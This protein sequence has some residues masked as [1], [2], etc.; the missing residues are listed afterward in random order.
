MEEKMFE[1]N[2]T[3]DSL[4]GQPQPVQ[5][6]PLPGDGP[7]K[8]TRGRCAARAGA[9]SLNGAPTTEL[10]RHDGPRKTETGRARKSGR[11]PKAPATAPAGLPPENPA[12]E[13]PGKPA[14]KAAPKHTGKRAGKSPRKATP[15]HTSKRAGKSLREAAP[16]DSGKAADTA[17]PDS[18]PDKKSVPWS[19]EDPLGFALHLIRETLGG[20]P[21]KLYETGKTPIRFKTT[22]SSLSGWARVTRVKYGRGKES[23]FIEFG[24]WRTGEHH[25]WHSREPSTS[26]EKEAFDREVRQIRE[27]QQRE[28]QAR[29]LVAKGKAARLWRR[30][31]AATTGNPY[32]Q[33][34]NVQPHSARTGWGG[35]SDVLFVPLR[36]AEWQIWNLQFIQPDGGK[37]FLKGGRVSGLFHPF[38]TRE[39]FERGKAILV[40]EGWA[41][42]ATLHEATG[43]PVAAAM[44]CGNLLPAA[45]ALREKFPRQKL[46]FCA[47]DDWKTPGNPGVTKAEKAA[48]SV[49]AAVVVPVWS[50]ARG[51]RGEKDT[52]FN[53]LARAEGLDAVRRQVDVESILS[54]PVRPGLDE[55]PCYWLLEEPA[56]IGEQEYKAGVYHCGIEHE[57]QFGK[58]VPVPT[59]TWL[60]S[61]I[62]LEA[63]TTEWP[64][65]AQGVRLAVQDGSGWLDV[66]L[67][68]ETLASRRHREILLAYGASLE[69]QSTDAKAWLVEYLQQPLSRREYTTKRTGW[70]GKQYVLPDTTIGKGK[71]ILFIGARATDEPLTA[72]ELADWQKSVAALAVGNPLLT[73]SISLAF[74]GPLLELTEHNAVLVHLVGRSTTGKTT[75]LKVANSVVGPPELVATWRATDNGLEQKALTYCDGFMALDEIGQ[76]K[77]DVLDN[78]IYTLANGVAKERAKAYEHGIGAAPSQRWRVAALSTGEKTLETLLAMDK[79]N[80]NAGQAVRFIEIPAEERHGAFTELHGYE[81]GAAL[82]DALRK[83][84]RQYYG[85]PIRAFLEQLSGEGRDALK[86]VLD[87][88]TARLLEALKN[89]DA[90]PGAQASRVLAS[91]A[92]VAA[93]GELATSYGITGWKQ[94]EALEAALHCYRLWAQRRA[95]G[96]DFEVTALLRQVHDFITRHGDSRFS[97]KDDGAPDGE[98]RNN[99]A[100]YERAG[101][102]CDQKEDREYLFTPD[103][104]REATRG[105]DFLHARQELKRLGVLAPGGKHDS[106]SVWVGKAK[107]RVYAVSLNALNRALEQI[108]GGE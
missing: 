35:L 70:H 39:D 13:K 19:H 59:E 66:V 22:G 82:A 42:G 55:R 86:Q 56:V 76:V 6:G 68:R 88:C 37:R 44:N 89:G 5:A 107:V 10:L 90:T 98:A 23:Y 50:G 60:S 30:A 92:L 100:V 7:R 106:Q 96:T 3:Q 34:K 12:P 63:R 58:V 40:C 36:D 16:D 73:F 83:A 18:K 48:C 31:R 33:R 8:K 104:F 21:E 65:G 105:F 52:D 25:E 57:K 75:C 46:V 47:D 24:D 28:E 97:A 49:G 80:V 79:R 15:E 1:L 99:P 4:H 64:D 102:Y 41:T 11:A 74:A 26:G 32:L 85:T 91:V 108:E 51:E 94:G 93:A 53:D 43:L 27:A 95:A 103:G 2:T 87:G 77:P 29:H 72:G 9:S 101:Y 67:P 84:V 20:A 78:A 38:G 69:A 71:T 45:R 61:P 17:A 62:R 81:S 14:E 54:Q